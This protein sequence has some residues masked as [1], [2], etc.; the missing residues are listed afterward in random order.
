MLTQFWLEKLQ[1]SYMWFS[2]STLDETMATSE[3][4]ESHDRCVAIETTLTRVPQNVTAT[5]A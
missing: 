5:V 3:Y 1:L 2:Q 4:D